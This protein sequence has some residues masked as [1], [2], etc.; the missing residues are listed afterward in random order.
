MTPKRTKP[1][2]G[3]RIIDLTRRLPGPLSTLQLAK[4]GAEVIKV[5]DKNSPDPFL[6]NKNTL[7]YTWATKLNQTKTTLELDLKNDKEKLEKI[8]S[9]AD[10]VFSGFS[11]ESLQKKQLQLKA[12]VLLFLQASKHAQHLHDLNILASSGVLNFHLNQF[13]KKQ[14][15][16]PPP[17][18]PIAGILFSEL[19][20][21]EALSYYHDF[22]KRGHTHKVTCYID[23]LIQENLAPLKTDIKGQ[24]HLHP[25]N[26]AYP[27]YRIYTSQDGYH[28]ALAALETRFW[29]LFCEKF[30]LS[31][32][33]DK[34]FDSDTETLELIEQ[35]F[36]S[37][38]KKEILAKEP[39]KLCLNLVQ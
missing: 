34:Q 6:S 32:L 31:L 20:S 8:C 22:L 1:L 23:E 26:G 7:F 10:I 37:L 36:L 11:Q 39:E 35:A 38:K 21:L 15:S 30:S 24:Q 13:P 14:K 27:C 19:L 17:L 16:Y 18:L 3:L 9:D 5:I 25:H 33:K 12:P 28:F 2:A 29:D 4:R